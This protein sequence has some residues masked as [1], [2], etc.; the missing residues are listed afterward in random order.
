MASSGELFQP[1]IQ[2]LEQDRETIMILYQLT[3]E[4]FSIL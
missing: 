2:L 4:I 3:G 1:D